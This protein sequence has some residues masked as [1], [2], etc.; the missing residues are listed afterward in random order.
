MDQRHPGEDPTLRPRPLSIYHPPETT[1]KWKIA[2]RIAKLKRMATAMRA[3][4]AS[5]DPTPHEDGVCWNAGLPEMLTVRRMSRA[6]EGESLACQFLTDLRRPGRNALVVGTIAPSEDDRRLPT[7]DMLAAIADHVD[8]LAAAMADPDRITLREW[9]AVVQAMVAGPRPQELP[10]VSQSHHVAASP[11]HPERRAD[12]VPHP[13]DPDVDPILRD[14]SMST[15][16]P[17]V[18]IGMVDDATLIPML[19]PAMV[20]VRTARDDEPMTTLRAMARVTAAT[21]WTAP[22]TTSDDDPEGNGA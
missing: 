5:G 15:G 4:A 11:I 1:P 7:T 2:P 6:D 10:F 8:L 13:S 22:A 17:A 16:L 18:M 3:A 19:V 14:I 9:S 21:G 20:D 12:I